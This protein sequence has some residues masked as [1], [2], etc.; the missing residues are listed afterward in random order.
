MSNPSRGSWKRLKKLC[1]YLKVMP[2]VVQKVKIGVDLDNVVNA[3]VGTDA[4]GLER[5]RTED[6]S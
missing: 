4:E 2:R 6:A 5:A 1:K 3:Y